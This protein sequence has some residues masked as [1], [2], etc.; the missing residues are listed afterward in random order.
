MITS[1]MFFPQ[2]DFYERPEDYKFVSDD[3]FLKTSDGI[4]IHGWF[5]QAPEQKGVLLFFHGNAGNI[6]HRLFKIK[7]WIDQG[8]SAFLLDYRGYGQSEGKI[9]HE[10]DVMKDAH[11]AFGWLTEVKKIP[12]AQVILYGESL[13]TH[14]A[15]RLGAEHKVGAVILEAAYTS[16]LDLASIHYPFVPKMFIRDFEFLNVD[17]I[18]QLKAPLFMLH[19]THDEICPYKMGI[20]IFEKAPAPKEFFT[21][22][23]GDHNNL[24]YVAG[25]DFWKKP[26]EFVSKY[27]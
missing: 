16:F 1:M 12:A 25:E 5:L 21:I 8:Y 23:Q 27:L 13:G 2:R 10:D 6:S 20:K 14:P 11:A 26:C 15:I 18:G 17:Y 22:P 3:V 4:K 24:P 7:G 19:G 9:E